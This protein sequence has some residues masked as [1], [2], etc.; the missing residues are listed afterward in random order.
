MP[1]F[2]W[3]YI[4]TVLSLLPLQTRHVKSA[5]YV[6]TGR[7]SDLNNETKLAL[8]RFADNLRKVE[9]ANS[10]ILESLDK[11]TTWVNPLFSHVWF[12]KRAFMKCHYQ[13]WTKL[14]SFRPSSEKINYDTGKLGLKHNI[15]KQRYMCTWL[16]S[17]ENW[18]NS[19]F[20]LR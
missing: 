8:K 17:F 13:R 9:F 3:Y 12:L 5:F 1:R 19:A 11:N 16:P 6:Q 20:L 14:I 18:V 15:I 10:T 4:A 2:S 7:N